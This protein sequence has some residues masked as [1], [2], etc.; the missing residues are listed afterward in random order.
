MDTSQQSADDKFM[1]RF[2][3]GLGTLL[4][5]GVFWVLLND[6]YVGGK[7]TS[8]YQAAPPTDRMSAKDYILDEKQIGTRNV[9]I[10]GLAS[11]F[12]SGCY[13]RDSE[14]TAGMIL[15]TVDDLDRVSRERLLSCGIASH[16][17]H[18]VVLGSGSG[19]SLMSFKAF[20]VQFLD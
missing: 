8:A 11:C 2:L 4:A 10:E 1:G 12:A 13:L 18:V 3:I 17:C 7:P 6:G 19:G 5:I 9:H 16:P 15:V 20:G 14:G